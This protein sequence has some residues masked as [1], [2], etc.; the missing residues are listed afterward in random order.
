MKMWVRSDKCCAKL[1]GLLLNGRTKNMKCGQEKSILLS[2]E[3]DV[4]NKSSGVVRNAE[5]NRL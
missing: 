2:E 3:L 4:L 1:L 5:Y